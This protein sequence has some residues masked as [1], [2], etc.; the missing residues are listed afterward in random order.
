MIADG[1][2]IYLSFDAFLL[3]LSIARFEDVVARDARLQVLQ[4]DFL[5]PVRDLHSVF[6]PLWDVRLVGTKDITKML[7]VGV[8]A[9]CADPEVDVYDVAFVDYGRRT[10]PA[11][12]GGR[13]EDFDT[14]LV[15]GRDVQ[16][17]HLFAEPPL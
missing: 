1:M 8:Q 11:W 15:P 14:G 4:H 17:L 7:H 16:R 6:Q 3:H 9:H 5:H 13:V 10:G 12:K 2:G